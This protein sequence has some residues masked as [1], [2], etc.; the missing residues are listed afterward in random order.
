MLLELLF[1]LLFGLIDIIVSLIPSFDFNIDLGILNPIKDLFA[2][3][4]NAISVSLILSILGI[5]IIRDNFT[6]IK[7]IF[8]AIVRK[9]PFVD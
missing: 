1:K 9:L 3:L 5:I 2:F 7:N 4:D 6:L 8:F